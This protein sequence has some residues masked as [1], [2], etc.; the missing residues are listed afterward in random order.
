MLRNCVQYLD[1]RS[2]FVSEYEELRYQTPNDADWDDILAIVADLE[3]ELMGNINVPWG[4]K[5]QLWQNLG[6]TKSGYGTYVGS[7]ASVPSGYVYKVENIALNNISGERGTTIIRATINEE[8][9]YLAY[10]IGLAAW[11]PLVFSGVLTLK[12]GDYVTVSMNHCLDNDI[13]YGGLVG[14]KMLV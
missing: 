8:N 10:T 7:S 2:T 4:Y 13:L 9:L 14:Y 1:R 12:A 11:Q 6:G 3:E 5:D